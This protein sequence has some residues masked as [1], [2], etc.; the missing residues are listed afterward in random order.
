MSLAIL[1]AQKAAELGE[2]PVG[3]VV[4]K[5]GEVIAKAH[6]LR[7]I[8]KNPLAHAEIIA[9]D[10]ASKHLGGW[11]LENCDMYVT[12]EPCI[13]CAGAIYQSRIRNLYFGASDP[14]SGA[15]QSLYNVLSDDRLNHQVNVYSGICE[16]ICS[17]LLKDFFAQLRS[18]KK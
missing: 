18:S 7:E 10:M 5:D 12:L 6:N 17:K 2:V 14:K 3:A 9:I 8:N 11:R 13:M 15:V 4:V 16:D 1:E